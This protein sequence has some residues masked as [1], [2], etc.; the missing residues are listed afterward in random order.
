MVQNKPVEA[1][2]ELEKA[3]SRFPKNVRIW[4]AQAKLLGIQKQTN[5]ALSLLDQAQKQLGDRVELRLQRAEL[6]LIK[7]GPQVNTDIN[8]LS[9]DLEPFSKED[10]HELLNALAIRSRPSA[11]P[12]RAP[13]ACGHDW[14]NR[15]PTT[16][17]SGSI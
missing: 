14:R 17:I 9:Q 15:S 13:A 7:G 11:G 6:L 4:V 16:S 12:S 10:R 1:Q 5:K 2:D 8:G 3:K